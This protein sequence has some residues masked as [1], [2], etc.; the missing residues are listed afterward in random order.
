MTITKEITAKLVKKFG[1]SE[2][3]TGNPSVQVAF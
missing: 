1:S 2:K 3:D